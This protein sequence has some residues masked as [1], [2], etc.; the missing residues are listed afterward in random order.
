MWRYLV[1]AVAALV[2]AGGGLWWWKSS[3]IAERAPAR[4]H[5]APASESVLPAEALPEPPVADEKTKEQ[6]RFARVDKDKDG[7]ITRDE[8]LNQR[9]KNF[10]KL[11]KNGDGKLSFDEYAVKAIDKFAVAD[12][13]RNGTLNPGEF[14]TTRVQRKT[15]PRPNCPPA[16]RGE[17]KGEDEAN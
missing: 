11:D 14:A 16:N 4:A 12:K 9:R 15:K 6:K 1:G 3:A 8:Y 13:D 5:Y 17:A 10:A 7:R 2:L